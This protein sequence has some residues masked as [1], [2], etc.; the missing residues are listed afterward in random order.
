MSEDREAKKLKKYE[1]RV[2]EIRKNIRTS[3]WHKDLSHHKHEYDSEDETY[4]EEEDMYEKKC[5]TCDHV[6]KYEKM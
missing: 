4:D 2:K 5:K 3:T 6:L 1:K